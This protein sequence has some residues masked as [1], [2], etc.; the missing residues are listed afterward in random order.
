MFPY[1]WLQPYKIYAYTIGSDAEVVYNGCNNLTK[2]MHIQLAA[3]G[4]GV[5]HGCNNLTKPM[6]IQ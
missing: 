1:A 2:S 4:H 6:H 3:D 5:A